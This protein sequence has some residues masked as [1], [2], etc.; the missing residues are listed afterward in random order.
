MHDDPH[1]EDDRRERRVARMSRRL[2]AVW[3]R[4]RDLPAYSSEAAMILPP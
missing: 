2:R 3:S 4:A 1:E